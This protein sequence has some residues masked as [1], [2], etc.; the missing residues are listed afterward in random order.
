MKKSFWLFMLMSF[1][2]SW[3]NGMHEKMIIHCFGCTPFSVQP[4]RGR[5][6]SESEFLAL[7]KI[8]YTY[9]QAKTIVLHTHQ[10]PYGDKNLAQLSHEIICEDLTRLRALYHVRDD[11]EYGAMPVKN[12]IKNCTKMSY[13]ITLLTLLAYTTMRAL[14]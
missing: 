11:S 8:Q 12:V 13:A 10:R 5:Y 7:L 1:T 2:E 3:C 6:P 9:E 14:N 4:F